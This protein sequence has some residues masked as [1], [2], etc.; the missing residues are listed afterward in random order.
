LAAEAAEDDKPTGGGSSSGSGSPSGPP[1]ARISG[2]P[3]QHWGAWGATYAAHRRPAQPAEAGFPF[4]QG[5]A[6]SG[7]NA[8]RGA[9]LP[10][11]TPRAGNSPETRREATS[12]LLQPQCL[13]ARTTERPGRSPL[14][15][16]FLLAER[17]LAQRSAALAAER[18]TA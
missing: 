4:S 15:R 17:L 9:S 16:S 5:P 13:N 6:S 18:R 3:P 8:A 7:A 11:E 1:P 14:C 2:I 12:R 10:A